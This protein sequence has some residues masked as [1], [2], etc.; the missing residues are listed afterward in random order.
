MTQNDMISRMLVETVAL[1]VTRLTSRRRL[2]CSSFNRRKW[3]GRGVRGATLLGEQLAR[4]DGRRHTWPMSCARTERA[5]VQLSR[6]VASSPKK[7]NPIRP[8]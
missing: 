7:K 8:S 3:N 2:A 4:S 5:Y 6:D 1:R